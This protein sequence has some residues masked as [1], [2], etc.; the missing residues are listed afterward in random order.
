MTAKGSGDR[1]TTAGSTWRALDN[2][3]FALFFAGQGLSLCGTWMQ[4]LAQSWLIYRL[5]G[6]PLLLGL[7][8][9]VS[10]VPVLGFGLLG[11]VLADRW[12]RHRLLLITQTLSLLQAM[13][14]AGLT[15]SGHITIGWIM[16]LAAVLGLIN[17]LDMPVRQ[18]FI[19]DL[20]PRADLPSAIG[21]N[22]S[23][24]NAARI[25]GPS[26]AGFLVA[27]VGEGVCFLVNALSFL[28]VIGC[29]LA[30]EVPQK[31][32][33]AQAHAIIFLAEGLRYARSTPHVRA[34]L[35]LIAVL[36][37]TAMPYT[38]LL[39]VFAGNVLHTDAHGLGW[40]MAATGMGALAGALRIARRGTIRGLGRLIAGA[41]LL[42]GVSLLALAAS[43]A[44]WFS[45]PV[46]LAVGYGMITGMAG[47]NTLL[48]SLVPDHLRGRVMSLYTLFFLGMAPIGSLMA[49]ALAAHLGTPL[50]IAAGGIGAILGAILFWRALPGI[51]RHVQE[52]GLMP[53][54]ELVLH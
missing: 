47:C 17:A 36:S 25:I 18:S 2:R 39:P 6:S 31:A 12:P 3:N 49:G 35:A 21:L 43:T 11:G 19:A 26:V 33:A 7:V 48:Q 53:P 23:A 51:R 28:A 4:S 38:V 15:L 5:T 54:E 8:G 24:F 14:L 9:F 46:L 50:T 42:F 22:S 37:L 41:A 27:A 30:M 16:G 44:L 52:Q 20:V 13:I 1:M 45:I 40:L 32:K 10:Q 29:L 34:V